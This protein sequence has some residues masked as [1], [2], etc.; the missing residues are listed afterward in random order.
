MAA[1]PLLRP[2]VG[3]MRR[4]EMPVS[5]AP[6]VLPAPSTSSV[7][8]MLTTH[9]SP[10]HAVRGLTVA[11][12]PENWSSKMIRLTHSSKSSFAQPSAREFSSPS[13]HPKELEPHAQDD[14]HVPQS[15]ER[16]QALPELEPSSDGTPEAR[17]CSAVAAGAFA[18]VAAC[19]ARFAR[20]IV[21]G[22]VWIVMSLRLVIFS[23]LLLPPFIRVGF[24][25][26]C[27]RRII[28]GK[29]FGPMARNYLDI[30]CPDEA[31]AARDG[32]EPL[33][34]VVI[35]VMG[36]AW[37]IG[38]RA[39]NAQL[40]DRLMD[41]GVLVFAI[42]YRNFPQGKIPDMVDDLT[43]GIEWVFQNAASYGG[44]PSKI[45]LTG[46]SAGAHLSSLLL[47]Q[48]SLAE[49]KEEEAHDLRVEAGLPQTGFVRTWRVRD[50]R[51]Y[52]GV[53]GVYDLHALGERLEVRGLGSVL[54]STMCP[55]GDLSRYSPTAL[56][57]SAE[58]QAVAARAV[59]MLPPVLLFHGEADKTVPW[60][61]SDQF[62]E[63]L[64]NSG[65]A[66]EKVHALV[67][68]GL[69][70][71]EVI[72]EGPMRGEDHQV[73]LLLPF[74]FG[75]EGKRHFRELPPLKPMYPR[76]IIALASRFMPF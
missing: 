74:L 39:W 43:R 29:R 49:A 7:R 50:L 31:V 1:T 10:P 61:I 59:P 18:S 3:T 21:C 22:V 71:A 23:V 63:A 64:R 26:F 17:G 76:C 69:A 42:D 5:R 6:S 30:Y 40:G 75:E 66:R 65:A 45:V 52:V 67:S 56:V 46:Q 62:A 47:L 27:D 12:V 9:L 57:N 55:D 34:P 11:A 8:P 72:I 70:H 38:H 19:G 2:L 32:S 51:G 48:R 37:V 15:F 60:T 33:V 73:Q 25:Y 14:Q 68:P 28:R 58:W 4:M 54:L 16:K 36:G 24:R 53:S 35:A 13:A 20:G 44:D 41:A